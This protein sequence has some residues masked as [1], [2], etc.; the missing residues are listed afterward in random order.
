MGLELNQPVNLWTMLTLAGLGVSPGDFRAESRTVLGKAQAPHVEAFLIP[1]P[2]HMRIHF[3]CLQM[4]TYRHF[5][6]RARLPVQI[7]IVCTNSYRNGSGICYACLRLAFATCGMT[8]VK[9]LGISLF[10]RGWEE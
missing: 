4:C 6:Y 5:E 1:G 10:V 3:M 9:G 8:G 7:Y 2:V